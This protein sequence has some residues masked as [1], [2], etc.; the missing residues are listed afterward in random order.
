MSPTR[1]S[2]ET[3]SKD[4]EVQVIFPDLDKYSTG[5]DSKPCGC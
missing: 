2:I 5:V 1:C 3:L 4:M